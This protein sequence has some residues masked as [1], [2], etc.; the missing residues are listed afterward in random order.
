[1]PKSMICSVVHF[2]ILLLYYQKV[3]IF[4]HVQIHLVRLKVAGCAG[5]RSHI[6]FKCDEVDGRSADEI[7]KKIEEKMTEAKVKNLSK[8]L[9]SFF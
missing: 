6:P 8:V 1:M 4:F 5:K 3:T 9:Y 2:A 7:R